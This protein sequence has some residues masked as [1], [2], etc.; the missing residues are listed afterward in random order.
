MAVVV[1][2]CRVDCVWGGTDESWPRD[3]L[4]VG[5]CWQP[6]VPIGQ[7][8]AEAPPSLYGAGAAEGCT[9]GSYWPE[10]VISG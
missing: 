4:W 1:W 10:N 8:Q 2:Q 5:A 3:F 6:N 9:I 7:P